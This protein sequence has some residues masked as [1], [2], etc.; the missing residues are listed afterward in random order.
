M[1]ASTSV[2]L[3]ISEQ[4]DTT[5]EEDDDDHPDAANG[6]HASQTEP[7]EGGEGERDLDAD[8]TDMDAT[9][10]MTAAT[11]QSDLSG[12]MDGDDDDAGDEMED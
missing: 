8:M 7:S 12:M 4:D 11:A 1:H 2:L 5:D 3:L 10:N 9:G 6:D